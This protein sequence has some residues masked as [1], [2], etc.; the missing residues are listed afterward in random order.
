[1]NWESAKS[2]HGHL[3]PWLA[4]GIK[5]GNTAIE[6]LEARRL[7][8]IMVDVECPLAPPPS[9]LIDGLQW[10][11]GATYG[12]QNLHAVD[13]DK[14]KV[15]VRNKDTNRQIQFELKPEIPA[16]LKFLLDNMGDESATYEVW[17]IPASDLFTYVL[18]ENEGEQKLN[19]A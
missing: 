5:I 18:I 12:K 16:K 10:S 4:L 2:F 14:V 7:F 1:M 11:T 9:C 6:K 13:A 19:N 3:G 17:D 15:T 8:G